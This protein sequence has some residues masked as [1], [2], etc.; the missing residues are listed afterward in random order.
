[1]ITHG[2]VLLRNQIFDEAEQAAFIEIAETLEL[3]H[4]P[5]FLGSFGYQ[6]Y[7]AATLPPA[8]LPFVQKLKAGR[9]TLFN[10]VF[11]QHYGVT[12]PGESYSVKPHRDPRNNVEETI[13][14]PFGQWRGAR[15]YV[16]GGHMDVRPGYSLVLPCTQNGKQGPM[17]S[18]S[19]I[20]EG[21]RWALILN[22]IL[23]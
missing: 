14:A 1:M 12:P 19:R 4:S 9:S 7:T 16:L 3:R 13:I 22:R 10:R 2:S 17:H 23:S 6:Q 11:V 20:D 8:L 15:H 18:V 5:N 21:Q